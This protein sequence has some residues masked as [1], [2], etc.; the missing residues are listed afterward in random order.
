MTKYPQDH[1]DDVPEYTDQVG[2]HR[3]AVAKPESNTGLNVLIIA[4]ALAL[5]VG[6]VA[7]LLLPQ[8]R[9]DWFGAASPGDD[10]TTE[11]PADPSASADADAD[12]AG[13]TGD[14]G[15]TDENETDLEGDAGDD[16]SAPEGSVEDPEGGEDPD[17]TGAAD[18]DYSQGI[19]VYNA[20]MTQGLAGLA[21]QELTAAGFNVPVTANWQGS[22]ITSSVVFYADDEATAQAIADQLGITAVQEPSFANIV[23]VLGDDYSG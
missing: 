9:T 23:V 18:V 5:V 12:D 4:A 6:I 1:Y 22:A 10:Q 20:T 21:S 17:P 13:E 8:L 14:A 19:E 16:A 15:T 3:A 11:A 7:F 2:A